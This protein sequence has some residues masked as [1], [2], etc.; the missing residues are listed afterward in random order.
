M[1]DYDFRH[2][3]SSVTMRGDDFVFQ[4]EVGIVLARNLMSKSKSD[5]FDSICH[6]VRLISRDGF[7]EFEAGQVTVCIMG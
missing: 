7:D 2:R 6:L 3:K 5:V 1:D 4:V